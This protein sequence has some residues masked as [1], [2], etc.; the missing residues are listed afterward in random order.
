MATETQVE[1]VLD[2]TELQKFSPSDAVIAQLAEQYMP[3]TINGIEDK[4]G[5]QKVHD[6]RMEVK[7]WR[8]DVEKKRKELKAD[9][10]EYGRKVDAEAKRITKMLE[11]IEQHLLSQ[12]TAVKE[13]IER[14]KEQKKREAEQKLADRVDKLRAV[15]DKTPGVLLRDWSD[16]GF[17]AHL[18]D[19]TA[20][21]EAEQARLEAERIEQEKIQQAERERMEAERQKLEE[22]RAEIERQ[23]AEAEAKRKAEEERLAEER[24]IQEQKLAAERAEL[25]A[26]RRRQEKVRRQQEAEQKAKEAAERARVETEQRIERER[27]AEIERQKAE[28]AKRLEEEEKR[29]DLEKVRAFIGSIEELKIPVLSEKQQELQNRIR[30]EVT[31]FIGY[32][33]RMIGDE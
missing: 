6:A 19:A 16:E 28:E 14:I 20:K 4:E 3:L 27:L 30:S 8:V 18:K 21:F 24:R 32:L 1:L 13:E 33:K 12:E 22:Q 9:A 2:T 17:E 5:L 15:G 23:R 7:R 26:E 10:L 29:P 31:D 25:E 11:P